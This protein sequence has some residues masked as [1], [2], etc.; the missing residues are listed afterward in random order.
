MHQFLETLKL[1]FSPVEAALLGHHFT[2]GLPRD[3]GQLAENQSQ[4]VGPATQ[5][6]H[7]Q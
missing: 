2:L 4:G 7:E 6:A 1:L 3:E 5:N